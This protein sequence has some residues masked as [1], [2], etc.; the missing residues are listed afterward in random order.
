MLT[1]DT[2]AYLYFNDFDQTPADHVFAG[3]GAYQGEKRGKNV[4]AAFE[5]GT[6]QND[7]AYHISIWMFNGYKDALNLWFRFIIEEHDE[8]QGQW[9]ETTF[10][11]DQSE[12]INGNW[13]L[14]EGT[15]RIRNSGNKV[16]IVTKGKENAKPPFIADDLLIITAETDVYRWTSD[17]T[18]LFYNNHRFNLQS[19]MGRTNE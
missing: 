12:V 18:V 2:A 6:F 14:A 7:Q 10:F 8:G 5:S 4:L 15:F 3:D 9:Y 17:S 19:K 13:S 11:P 1:T 16:Y